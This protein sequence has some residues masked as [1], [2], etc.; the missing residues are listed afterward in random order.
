MSDK[1]HSG[2]LIARVLILV[3]ALTWALTPAIGKPPEQDPQMPA[4]APPPDGSSGPDQFRSD[5]KTDGQ[6]TP[7][8]LNASK[9][10]EASRVQKPPFTLNAAKFNQ[11]IQENDPQFSSGAGKFDVSAF[12]QAPLAGTV[13]TLR[14]LANYDIELLV[15]ESMS[16]RRMDCPGGLS[17]WDWCG[18][19]AGEL[20]KQLAPF[21][22]NGFTLTTFGGGYNVYNNSSPDNVLRLFQN[23]MF[24]R[25]TRMAEPLA[26]RLGFHFSKEGNN[27]SSKPLLIAVI[28]DGVPAP[29]RE[30]LMVADV[31][32]DT[33]KRMRDPRDVTVVFFQIGQADMQGRN[34]LDYLDKHLMEDGAR[35]DI[36]HNVPMERLQEI[37]LAQALVDSI[38]SFAAKNGL[39]PVHAARK[40]P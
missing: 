18:M 3:F 8:S 40:E 11:G 34:F 29:R 39:P 9:Q 21:V 20:A 37:G 6:H 33:T 23:P 5:E 2:V 16:M 19:Q 36:V 17:R 13:Q 24:T 4:A 28:T 26:E 31:L 10:E 22:R 30:P 27:G 7:F 14:L 25:G 38:H 1:S 12:Q 35:Y 15:D 32:I